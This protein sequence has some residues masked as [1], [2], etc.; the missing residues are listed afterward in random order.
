MGFFFLIFLG[1][2]LGKLFV[3]F[4]FI[5]RVFKVLNCFLGL[6]F[7]CVKDEKLVVF[8]WVNFWREDFALVN[9]GFD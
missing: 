8:L 4:C 6:I 9:I 7:S 3:V 2:N 1:F 5:L